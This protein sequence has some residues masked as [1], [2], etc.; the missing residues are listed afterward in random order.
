M[1]RDGINIESFPSS[2]ATGAAVTA[3]AASQVS[4]KL[5]C[6]LMDVGTAALPEWYDCLGRN[7]TSMARF[8]V[9]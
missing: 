1:F 5:A 3:V 9:F 7:F 8:C 4:M 2:R 6:P